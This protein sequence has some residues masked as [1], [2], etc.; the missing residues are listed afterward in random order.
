MLPPSSLVTLP[1]AVAVQ[2]PLDS[3]GYVVVKPT[4]SSL[5]EVPG[6]F[7]C[8]DVV[9]KRYRQAI[10]AAGMGCMAAMDCERWLSHSS[11]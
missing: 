5:T 2:V 7:A 8:G 6:I 10:T 9:D 11:S 4:G 1:P 3:D